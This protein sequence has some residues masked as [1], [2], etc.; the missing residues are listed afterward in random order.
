MSLKLSEKEIEKL[1]NAEMVNDTVSAG[2]KFVTTVIEHP[3]GTLII[4]LSI[5]AGTIFLRG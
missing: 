1:E 5:Y 3:V 4:G 2:R